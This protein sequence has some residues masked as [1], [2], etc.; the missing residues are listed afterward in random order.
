MV[1][2]KHG[3]LSALEK[4]VLAVVK[5]SIDKCRGISHRP[6]ESGVTFHV[7][8][9]GFLP[10]KFF[11]AVDL[12]E[13]GVANLHFFLEPFLEDPRVHHIADAYAG[14][15]HFVGVTRTDAPACCSDLALTHFFFGETIQ[16]LM[17]GEHEVSAVAYGEFAF[18]A[19]TLFG[20]L[21]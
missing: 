12:G 8:V 2:V 18:N 3:A 4:N 1:D 19:D 5:G 13:E 21:I 11:D 6:G 17:V 10:V 16:T 9:E 20:K 7:R 15:Q 14:S